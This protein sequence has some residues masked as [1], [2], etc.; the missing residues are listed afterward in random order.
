MLYLFH[1]SDSN[2]V[3]AKAFQ[4]VAATRAKAP[5]AYYQRF[6][7]GDLSEAALRDALS[8]QG[9][10]FA[11][12]LVLV[13]DPFEKKEVADLVLGML[14]ELAASPN[15]VALVAPK[16]I[17]ARVRKIESHAE[18]VFKFDAKAEPKRGF[19]NALVEAL[20]RRDG[21]ALWQELIKTFRAGDAPEKVHG[22]LHWKAR[23]L[24]ERGGQAW[25]REQARSL[26]IELIELLA[27]SR[28]RGL[29]LPLALER[30]ALSVKTETVR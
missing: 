18:K 5:N 10:F 7:A 2:T 23:Q 14:P 1:G 17:P 21:A 28:S 19:N 29:P 11:K 8:R 4:W 15:P 26:S 25:S 12:S 24:M 6:E 27:D 30:F 13:D 9:L 20:A 22:L 16:L 3:R